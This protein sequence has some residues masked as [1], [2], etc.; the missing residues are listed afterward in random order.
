MA[1]MPSEM[2]RMARWWTFS[3]C[4][5]P[6]YDA[7]A[8]AQVEGATRTHG[9][10]RDL[11]RIGVPGALEIGAIAFAHSGSIRMTAISRSAV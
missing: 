11:W 6:F 3:D 2:R 5:A 8:D 1:K 10:R 9:I 7:L 4:R